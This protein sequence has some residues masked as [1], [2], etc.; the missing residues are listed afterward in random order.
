MAP[1]YAGQQK[2]ELEWNEANQR[3]EKTLTD[4]ND[5]AAAGNFVQLIFNS[6]NSTAK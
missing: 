2:I 5:L 3:Y 4:A 6:S 1:S